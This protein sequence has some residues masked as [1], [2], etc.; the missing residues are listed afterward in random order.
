VKFEKIKNN[1]FNDLGFLGTYLVD[2]V[3]R[4]MTFS[5]RVAERN[6]EAG[7]TKGERNVILKMYQKGMTI[8]EI[9]N[10]CDNFNERQIQEIISGEE[11]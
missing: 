6:L 9:Q 5:E 1:Y 8:K 4:M 11:I 10:I 3:N 2:E 7:I